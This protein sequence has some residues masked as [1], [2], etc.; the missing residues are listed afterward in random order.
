MKVVNKILGTI[1]AVLVAVMVLGCFWQ[2]VT[3]FV[4]RNP[5]KYTEE[6]IRYA[7]I[8]LTMLG[9]PY[10][11]GRNKHL[12]IKLLTDRFDPRNQIKNRIVIEVIVMI[13]SIAIFIVG[14]IMVTIN[15]SGQISPALQM[16]M[17]IYYAGLPICGILMVLFGIE[18]IVESVK[19]LKGEK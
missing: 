12:S 14:G 5:S 4:L 6:F 17:E 3:R 1:I 13:F 7:L 9:T 16:P 19:E 2:V 15:S 18:H 10:A 11:F 8:W